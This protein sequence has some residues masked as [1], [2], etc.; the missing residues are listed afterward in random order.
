MALELGQHGF[1]PWEA[2]AEELALAVHHLQLETVAH[3]QA[4]PG[5][6]VVAHPHQHQ[7]LVVIEDALD[8]HLDPPAR[9]LVAEQPGLDHPRVVE[10]QEVAGPQHRRQ[11][12][13]PGIAD[14]TGQ[15][16]HEHQAARAAFGQRLLGNQ[17]RREVVVEIVESHPARL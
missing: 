2:D 8:Q 7:R 15:A 13:E 9:G 10:H 16:I 1:L 5:R 3:Q 14:R 6:R 12:L 11:V 4:R 17:F